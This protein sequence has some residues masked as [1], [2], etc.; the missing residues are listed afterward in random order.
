MEAALARREGF[1]IINLGGAHP[2]TLTELVAAVESATG[3]RAKLDRQPEQPGDVPVTFASV[4]KAERV[5]NFRA[6]VPLPEGLRRA[7]EW[8]R[9][10][11]P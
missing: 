6:R 7:V 11:N 1:E 2:V 8:H 5:L 10:H 4:A 3:K 9:R